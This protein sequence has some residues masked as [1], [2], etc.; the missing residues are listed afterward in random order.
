MGEVKRPAGVRSF[1][2]VRLKCDVSLG[3]VW[4][5]T[6]VSSLVWSRLLAKLVHMC[7][8]LIF[9]MQCC[10]E[11]KHMPLEA[12]IVFGNTVILPLDKV[13]HVIKFC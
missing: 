11:F 10:I 12:R 7:K 4:L 13:I 6:E 1:D 3:K 9:F 2:K 5:D 8:G